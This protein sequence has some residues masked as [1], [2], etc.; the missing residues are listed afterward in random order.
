MIKGP[1]KGSDPSWKIPTNLGPQQI[2]HILIHAILMCIQ[3][4]HM[5]LQL[6]KLP[7]VNSVVFLFVE[8]ESHVRSHLN[9]RNY[10]NDFKYKKPVVL[11]EEN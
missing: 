11:L 3:Q 7:N 9:R 10:R 1:F 5:C 8:R 2:H 4:T 6:S